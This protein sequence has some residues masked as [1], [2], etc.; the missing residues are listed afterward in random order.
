MQ[1]ASARITVGSTTVMKHYRLTLRMS[2]TEQQ[3]ETT[4]D[5]LPLT[6]VLAVSKDIDLFQLLER[7]SRWS[8]IWIE[9]RLLEAVEGESKRFALSSVAMLKEGLRF[10]TLNCDSD[11]AVNWTPTYAAAY[12]KSRVEWNVGCL[13]YLRLPLLTSWDLLYSIEYK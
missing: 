9:V 5:Q 10:S 6:M 11:E 3:K 4:T 12:A 7:T 1:L 8:P 13:W 2:I